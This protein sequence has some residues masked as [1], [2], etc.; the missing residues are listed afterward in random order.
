M[1]GWMDPFCSNV[2][3]KLIRAPLVCALQ[4]LE[5]KSADVCGISLAA[6]DIHRRGAGVQGCGV[7][8]SCGHTTPLTAPCRT[9]SW[10]SNALPTSPQHRR[11]VF[12]T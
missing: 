1:D 8:S 4:G 5:V 2:N 6:L 3:P 10:A 11:A 7:P 12:A 9:W